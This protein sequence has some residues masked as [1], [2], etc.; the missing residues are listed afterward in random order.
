[1]LR[2]GQEI[3]VQVTK[4][5]MGNKGARVI[6]H[7]SL[8]GRY[9]VLM[10]TVEYIGIS[11]R[12]E[13]EGEQERLREIARQVKPKNMGVIVRTAAEGRGEE[14]LAKDCQFLPSIME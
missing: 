8:P 11:R 6:G 5:A 2:E 3:I 7:L 10:P 9:L 13:D 4:E 14:E 12:I 1:M